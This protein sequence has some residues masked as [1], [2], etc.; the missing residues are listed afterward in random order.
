[1]RRIL[2]IV[3]ASTLLLAGLTTPAQAATPKAGAACAKAGIT[4]VVKAGTKTT[5]FTCVKSGK[6]SVWNKGVVTIAAPAPTPTPTASPTPEQPLSLD[7]LDPAR[8]RQ[9]AFAEMVREYSAMPEYSPAIT[10]INGPNVGSSALAAERNGLNSATRFWGDIFQPKKMFVSYFVASDAD[11]VDSAL[12]AQANNCVATSKFAKSWGASM[13]PDPAHCTF[14]E[15][16]ETNDGVPLM[17][18]CIG[19]G[20]GDVHNR[21]TTPHE[22]THL[23]Q[24][25]FAGN[26][27]N[28]PRWFTEGSAVYFGGVLGLYSGKTIPKDLNYVL[29]YDAKSWLMQTLCPVD[30]LDVASVVN[31][32]NFSYLRGP[33]VPPNLTWQISS[34]SYYPGS[35]V[36]EAMVAIYGMPKIKAFMKSLTANNFDEAF[37]NSFGISVQDFYPKAAKYV[38]AM[39]EKGL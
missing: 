12:C 23:V 29:R 27:S 1:M 21:Q 5:K 39:Y 17:V 33:S 3:V 32:F 7:N 20:N 37:F 14:G 4:Q 22:F 25:A 16:T 28:N 2:T 30:K 13:K 38:I 34:T 9:A 10:F 31:C 36:T 8:I 26:F 11:W 24:R 35:L 19:P 15:A 18:Q 6:K